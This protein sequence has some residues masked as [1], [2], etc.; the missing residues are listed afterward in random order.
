MHVIKQT[1]INLS[2]TV[3]H[4]SFHKLH[5]IFGWDNTYFLIEKYTTTKFNILVAILQIGCKCLHPGIH[6]NNLIVI[7]K[8]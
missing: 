6:K 7:P 4:L 1:F 2:L 5:N 3:E 8:I